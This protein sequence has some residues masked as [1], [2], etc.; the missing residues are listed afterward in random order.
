[1]EEKI[2]NKISICI[3]IPALMGICGVSRNIC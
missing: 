1:M 2:V 3:T